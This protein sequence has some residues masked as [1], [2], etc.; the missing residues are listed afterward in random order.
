MLVFA[1][2]ENNQRQGIRVRKVLAPWLAQR[3]AAA[4]ADRRQPWTH[5]AA[6]LDDL[7]EGKRAKV[8][9]A[10]TPELGA[11]LARWWEWSRDAPYQGGWERRAYRSPDPAHSRAARWEKLGHFLGLAV[12]YPQ[13][14]AWHAEWLMHASI[15]LPM[16]GL[17]ASA[18]DAGRHD[19]AKTLVDSIQG[20]HPVSGP[21]SQAY[22][23]LLAAY[24][25]AGWD[26][27]VTQ[28]EN[29]QRAEGLRQV[30]L[31]AV[32]LAHPH[33]F[34]RVLACVVEL[35]LTRFA[36]TVRAAGVW[37]GDELEI[38]QGRQ[39]TEALRTTLGFLERPP[40]AADLRDA[41]ATTA[42]LG[43][44]SLATRDA[45]ATVPV[46]AALLGHPDERHRL[47][48]ARLL[49]D[50]A[51]PSAG[52]ALVPALEDPALPV[53]AAAVAAWP[54]YGKESADDLPARVRAA[55]MT[56]V[57]SLGKTREVETGILGH[58]G[59][60]VGAALAADVLVAHTPDGRLEPGL[61]A[62]ATSSGRYL[63]V[64]RY[65]LD[66]VRHRAVLFDF[67]SD[68]SR[69]VRGLAA[70]ALAG[71]DRITPEEA[72]LLEQALTRKTADLRTTALTLLQKQ[73]PDAV[74]ASVARLVSGTDDQRRAAEELGRLTGQARGSQTPAAPEIPS[75]LRFTTADRT[76]AARP[77]P[78]AETVWKD[79][80]RGCAL[81]RS[82]LGAWLDEHADTE[83]HT[84]SGVELLANVRWIGHPTK[85][86]VPLAEIVEPW[87][88][89]TKHQLT[90]GGVEVA[91]LSL[92][93]SDQRK[94]AR[95]VNAVV[96]G[97]TKDS[98]RDER[99]SFLQVQLISHLAS[100]AWRPSWVDPVL[101]MLDTAA[102][103]LPIDGLM[104][105]PE[106]MARRGRSLQRN[107]WGQVPGDDDRGS[108]FRRLFCEVPTLID[109]N[110]LTDEQLARLWRTARFL[111]EPEGT[112]DPYD[113]P[114]VEA[115]RLRRFGQMQGDVATVPDRPE[116]YT[117]MPQLVA[118]AFERGVATRADIVDGLLLL[119]PPGL[120]GNVWMM[121]RNLLT[122]AL[123][124]LRP[125]PWAAGERIQ[126]VVEE[127]R[128]AVIAVEEQRGDLPTLLS[129]T[130]RALRTA[131]GARSLVG[132]V[133]A[134]GKRPLARGYAWNDS[135]ESGLSHLVRIHQP[136]T[137]DTAEELGRLAKAAKITDKRLVETAVYAP[138]WGRLI[139]AHLDWPGLESAVWWVH[140]HT[141]D[142][143]WTVDA[144]IRAQWAS[145]VSQRTPLDSTDLV[146]GGADVA[147]FHDMLGTLG[148]ERFDQ[149]LAAAKYA[150]SS[151]GHKRAELFASSLRGDV[152][153]EDLLTRIHDKRHQ[154]A[155]RALGLFPLGEHDTEAV[156]LRR[157]ETLRAFVASDRASGSM[158][159]ASESTAVEVG[160]ENLART[161]G[162]R[163]PQ[164][165]IWAMEA[166]AV[167]DLVDGLVS[168]ADGDLVVTLSLDARGAATITAQRAGKIL[169]SLPAK[170][171]KVPEIAALRERA[172]Q[173][174]R[175]ARRM[176]VSLEA[177]CVLGD[178][179]E[180]SEL[181]DLLRHPILA[182]MLR[183]LVLVSAEGVAG[184]AGTDPGAVIGPDGAPRPAHGGG[185]R[186][187]HPLDLL[188]TGEWPAFQHA[189][190]EQRRTQPFKQLFREL[191]T[192]SS[193]ERDEDGT[194]SRRYAGHQ[195][196]A[197]RAG[198]IF[199]SRGWVSDFEMGFS[200]T[201][202]REKLTAWCH[203][204]NGLGS[205][206]EVEDA[207]VTDVSF[208][209]AGS[210]QPLPLADVPGRLFSEV[211][212]DLD[213]VVSVAHSSGVDP[214]TSAS[215]VE[216]RARLV[217]E[218]AEL[219]G[220]RNVEV[221][222]HHARVKGSLGTYS[223]HLGSGVV[224]RIPGHA[225]CIVP[226]SAQ[227][228]GRIF[229]PFADDDPRTA[230]VVAKV[231]LLARDE[232]IKDPT[233]IEQLVR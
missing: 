118:V 139:E 129:P 130:A 39:L 97:P 89:R 185:L 60:K 228:R 31:E 204:L 33:A 136:R 92:L 229:L 13:P 50:L 54:T 79:Y 36:S 32:D 165:L 187:A 3:I 164:R 154:D 143:S 107:E 48:A 194:T 163:D 192:L 17:L 227:H 186:V 126:A 157:Y 213:L 88:E 7:S 103:H 127:V 26:V 170:S 95:R 30:I 59:Q 116:R 141:K 169:K 232:T 69:N 11:D 211:M 225:V 191:Y 152:S 51:L 22:A 101:D 161:A 23:A 216:M 45:P 1:A 149:V 27:V 47:A 133:A 58:R 9:S 233:I 173:L 37:F 112:F 137:S 5:L 188:E 15:Y 83:V 180:P 114:R 64:G 145:E 65:A 200:R 77:E 121:S 119:D 203:L 167:R 181:A 122:A 68:P 210:W 108:T 199:T 43:L 205:P 81:V 2:S 16:G 123:T 4:F 96:V 135:R 221:G 178:A 29:A 124:A 63:A 174:K 61:A 14:L 105:E 117:P 179:F 93:G 150:S 113:G 195:L 41:D 140:A 67:L 20:S 25:P 84:D 214:E 198:G 100:F 156:L 110:E 73:E 182:P 151:G 159:R 160:M 44:W 104:A 90:D 18:I 40:S 34:A 206:T 193:G 71:M 215:S 85:G 175:Q 146:R 142:D 231:V 38:R 42:Y 111:D 75:V 158:R 217:E 219:L 80:H 177:S 184:F 168:A 87:W 91:L 106:V 131:Y 196:E 226:V 208:H 132:V 172:T 109:L 78:P 6:E 35:D 128:A 207:T 57:Q 190:M 74:A 24:D 55:L 94:W 202:H 171:A 86:T 125:E 220:L 10:L 223:I 62:A 166:T 162:Y 76:P 28:L 218:T 147:W 52:E 189:L 134:L 197:R 72:T 230:E 66:P 212:R 99:V 98:P 102:A 224:H 19:I 120:R 148:P 176:R 209:P 70:N 155:V 115:S 82:S 201:F 49:T 21:S 8:L 53:Y 56:R 153:E 222:G 46:A 183:D 138:Q 144:E 12:R